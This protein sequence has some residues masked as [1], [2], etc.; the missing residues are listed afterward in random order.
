MGNSGAALGRAKRIAWIEQPPDQ[1]P[2]VKMSQCLQQFGV[3]YYMKIDIEG[4][5]LFCLRALE[6]CEVRPD[7]VSLESEK[8]V[9]K[10]LVE[11]F[12]LL[13]A[14]GY[15][16]F[17]IVQQATIPEQSAPERA[18]EGAQVSHR[19]EEG[20]SG[21]FGLELPGRWLARN[22]ALLRYAW[23][24]ALYS[25]FGDYGVLSKSRVGEKL[26]SVL[27]KLLQQPIPGWYDTH[28]RHGSVSSPNIEHRLSYQ[29]ASRL[30]PL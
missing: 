21:V 15:V 13:E 24:F 4:A 9:F 11:E 23:I 29:Y 19:F 26:R 6:R 3:P 7:Y 5:D 16:R 1:R 12:R 27:A 14:L 25:M 28:A 8:R 20:A 22:T 30:G 17:K 10:G 18:R 2:A